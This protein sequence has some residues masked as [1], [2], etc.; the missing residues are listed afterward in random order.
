MAISPERRSELHALLKERERLARLLAGPPNRETDAVVL[1]AVA[2][3]VFVALIVWQTLAGALAP[4]TGSLP[5][6]LRSPR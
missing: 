6:S 3:L 1:V 4:L 5:P 2:A